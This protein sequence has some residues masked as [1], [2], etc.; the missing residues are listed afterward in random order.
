M[1]GFSDLKATEQR[2]NDTERRSARIAV[3]IIDPAEAHARKP[4]AEHL[5]DYA[6][7]LQA[8]GGT[9][10]HTKKTTH[11]IEAMLND[12]NFVKFADVDVGQ[13]TRWLNVLRHQRGRGPS[14]VNHDIR[15]MRCFFS[16]LVEANR[17]GKDPLRSLN[18]LDISTDIRRQ[19][20]PL[21]QATRIVDCTTWPG[22]WTNSRTSCQTPTH[23]IP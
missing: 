21:P 17:L 1:K 12:C 23:R 22:P 18:L 9:T 3:G 15:A 2:A 10:E 6:A 8:K 11:R 4:L 14:T 16:W 13:V 5:T 7:H 19:H 20:R